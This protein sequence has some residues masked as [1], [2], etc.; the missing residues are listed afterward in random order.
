MNTLKVMKTLTHALLTVVI[1]DDQASTVDAQH[2]VRQPH[3]E[4][5]DERLA[6]QAEAAA[7]GAQQE[8][9]GSHFISSTR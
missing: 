5:A 7:Y 2:L 3:A 9:V 4:D 8:M 1:L 6:Q